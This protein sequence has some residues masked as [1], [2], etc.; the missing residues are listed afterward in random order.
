MENAGNDKRGL[1]TDFGGLLRTVG[2][3]GREWVLGVL[4]DELVDVGV[5]V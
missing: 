1:E 4:W 5:N 2:K 3:S